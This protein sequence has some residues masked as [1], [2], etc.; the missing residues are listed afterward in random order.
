MNQHPLLHEAAILTR[1]ATLIKELQQHNH[2]YYILNQPMITD[3]G[4]DAMLRELKELERQLGRALQH[5]PTQ[6]VGS[7]LSGAFQKVKHE[8]PMLSLDNTFSVDEI[9]KFFSGVDL[10]SNNV[11]IEP[12]I[13]GL[14]L[15]LIYEN[16]HLV[17][18]VTRGDGTVGEDVTA[19][20]RAIQSIPLFVPG[21]TAEVRGEVYM[22]RSVFHA[23][24][25]A[26]MVAGEE[27]YANPRNLAS[28]TMKQKSPAEVAKRKLDFMAYFLLGNVTNIESRWEINLHGGR[29]GLLAHLGFQTPAQTPK[30]T[31]TVNL[32]YPHVKSTGGSDFTPATLQA[33]VDEIESERVHLDMEIDGVV[34]KL[35]FLPLQEELGL[36]SKSPRWACAYKFKPE[37]VTTVLAD[38]EITVG[39][40]GQVTPN[41]RLRPVSLGGVMVSNASLMN[42]DELTRIGNPALGDVVIVERSA[43]VIPR[44]VGIC[45]RR[46]IGAWKFPKLC[47]FCNTAL[48]K[49]GVHYFDP[50]TNCPE[51]VYARLRHATAKGALDWDGMGEAQIRAFILGGATKLS[52]LFTSTNLGWMKPAALKKFMSERERVKTQPLWRKLAALG[53]ENVGQGSCKDLAQ[54]Y[55]SILSISLAPLPELV[56][57][58]GPVA[59]TSLLDFMVQQSDEIEAL[60]TAGLKFEEAGE[61]GPL[62]GKTFVITG[63]LVT[64]TRDQVSARIEKLGGLVKS[65][66]NKST[67][68]LVVGE[69][70]G[71]NK[72]A[73]AKKHGTTVITEEELYTLMGQPFEP[74]E[75]V[76]ETEV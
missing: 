74:A 68:Y 3:A 65:G 16:G 53:I 64:G 27:Q 46:G 39:R 42:A 56:A 59:A 14:S 9:I 2:Q 66:V 12:K 47:P 57:L 36:K 49:D 38:I 41:A 6:R 45:E 23:L 26:L 11:N 7:D 58:L 34:I 63:S 32:L 29:V 52:D 48:V 33:I 54:K 24:N 75:G 76:E 61:L 13:D 44:V 37:Q 31:G 60:D 73:A 21:L 1:E 71:G 62:C 51:Q 17:R 72:T 5:S 15:S 30:L 55:R 4:F 18:A 22:R 69:A 28:G 20:A 67:N 10:P 43:E 70:P 8:R 35:G 50:N 40:T 25:A 19:N